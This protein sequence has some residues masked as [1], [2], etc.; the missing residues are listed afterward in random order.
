MTCSLWTV[1]LAGIFTFESIQTGRQSIPE[2]VQRFSKGLNRLL[3][4]IPLLAVP[5][6]AVLFLCVLEG[7]F[8][9]RPCHAVPLLCFYAAAFFTA[10]ANRNK[11][12]SDSSVA[13]Q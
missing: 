7:R 6:F 10:R 12:N 11:G 2:Q 4:L 8:Y 9:E 5:V 1:V 3:L 13:E